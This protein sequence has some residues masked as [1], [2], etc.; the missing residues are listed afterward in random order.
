MSQAAAQRGGG[1]RP[2]A[3][4]T[5]LVREEEEE[6][7]EKRA[8]GHA[9]V[10]RA[11]EVALEANARRMAQAAGN[12]PSGRRGRRGRGGEVAAVEAAE[13][14]RHRERWW[15]WRFMPWRVGR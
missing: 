7:V 1:V 13:A 4:L 14:T 12:V 10:A 9:G 2:S 3:G 11:S 8:L 5:A 6:E 15:W